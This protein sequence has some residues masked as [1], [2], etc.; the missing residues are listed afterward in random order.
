MDNEGKVSLEFLLQQ[1]CSQDLVDPIAV[2]LQELINNPAKGKRQPR[3]KRKPSSTGSSAEKPPRKETRMAS[4]V[5]SAEIARIKQSQDD[6]NSERMQGVEQQQPLLER[7]TAGNGPARAG[8][9]GDNFVR[10][11]C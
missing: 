7:V 10:D 8:N 5:V 2:D 3:R 6:P 4:S 1:G 11:F 9:R